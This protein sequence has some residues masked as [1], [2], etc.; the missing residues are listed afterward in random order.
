MPDYLQVNCKDM[1]L[2]STIS[3]DTFAHIAIEILNHLTNQPTN[4]DN[5][6]HLEG[7]GTHTGMV[8][9]FNLF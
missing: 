4:S 9:I 2:S 8:L 1:C 3:S 5:G 7:Q 6:M